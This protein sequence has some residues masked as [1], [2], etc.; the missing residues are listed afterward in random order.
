MPS[1]SV[2]DHFSAL[3]RRRS[4]GDRVGVDVEDVARVVAAQRAM[5]ADEVAVS[6]VTRSLGSIDSMSPDDAEVD[7]LL[8]ASSRLTLVAGA[9]RR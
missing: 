5:T 3:R 7:D 8:D 6:S 1:T 4:R 9:S 2:P